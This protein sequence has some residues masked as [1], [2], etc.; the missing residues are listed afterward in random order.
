VA[1]NA[2]DCVILCVPG[3]VALNAVRSVGGRLRPGSLWVDTTSVKTEICK[4]LQ[5]IAGRSESLS[6]N[7]MSAPEFGMANQRIAVVPVRS[8]PVAESFES[9]LRSEGAILVRVTAEEHDRLTAQIQVATHAALIVFGLVL[10]R[11]NYSIP[12][13]ERL[14]TPPHQIMMM[15][16]ARMAAAGAGVYHEIQHAHPGGEHIREEF[17]KAIENMGIAARQAEPQSLQALLDEV[18]GML[19]SDQDNLA[20][21]CAGLLQSMTTSPASTPPQSGTPRQ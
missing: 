10:A 20:F 13:S 9:W 6:I 18:R 16:L 1:L 8:G 17:A 12:S 11:Q 4:Q 7:P 3:P 5:T 2:S 14:W 21:R 19:G 15:L